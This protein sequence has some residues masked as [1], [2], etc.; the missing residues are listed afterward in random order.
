MT[1][2]DVQ[3]M[4]SDFL[5]GS[6][7]PAERTAV[8]TH[9]ASCEA[10]RAVHADLLRLRG[11]ART[12]GPIAPPDHVWLEVAGQIRLL[13]APRAAA[14]PP[15]VSRAPAPRERR[16][17]AGLGQWLGLAAALVLVTLGLYWF[18]QRTPLVAPETTAGPAVMDPAASELN[19]ALQ[20][21]ER[22]ISELQSLAESGQS[23]IDPALADMIQ[24][25][26]GAIDQAI[27]ESRTAL[28][29]NP[30]SE[31]ARASLFDALSRK[32]TTLQTTVSL[33]NEM[34]QGDQEG[35]ARVAQGQ[36]S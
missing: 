6:L 10:C 27:A 16:S 29:T 33:I 25:S 9:L 8:R 34:S 15:A 12:L 14:P 2:H 24:Q 36:K 23:T 30:D 35:A 21:Y 13:D 5:D 32:I 19:L 20:E 11:A 3:R 4:L 1:C 22:A 31:P 26:L 7:E 18:Q 28:V 17:R